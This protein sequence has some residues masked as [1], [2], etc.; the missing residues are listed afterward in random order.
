MPWCR[1]SAPLEY[2]HANTSRCIASVASVACRYRISP[3]RPPADR[4]PSTFIV[5]CV[6]VPESLEVWASEG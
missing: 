2:A 4:S 3:I 5:R 6:D 1:L